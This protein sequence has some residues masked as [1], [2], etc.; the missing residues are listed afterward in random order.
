MGIFDSAKDA[1]QK[2]VKSHPDQ[3]ADAIDKVE[4][5]VDKKTGGKYTDQISAGGDRLAGALGVDDRAAGGQGQQAQPGQPGEQ[6]QHAPEQQ[7]PGEQ[8][9]G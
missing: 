5:V 9:E 7:A 3:V 6:V 1:L 2:A 4:G 8:Q